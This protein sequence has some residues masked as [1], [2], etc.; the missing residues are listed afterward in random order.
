MLPSTAIAP[1]SLQAAAVR[2]GTAGASLHA[3]AEAQDMDS[4]GGEALGSEEEGGTDGDAAEVG[5]V[6]WRVPQC[7]ATT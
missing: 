5:C 2:S 3:G 4:E 1:H 6:S 7:G